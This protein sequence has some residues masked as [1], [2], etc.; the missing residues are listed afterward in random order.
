M[1]NP[2]DQFD[3]KP[4]QN[5]VQANPFNQFDAIKE[6][7]FIGGV[8]QGAGDVLAGAVR[9]AG[10]IGATLLTPVDAAFRAAGVENEWVGRTDRRQAMDEALKTVGA[11]T[12]STAFGAGKLG[13]EIAGTAAA[14]GVLGKVLKP[15]IGAVAPKL[16]SA[17]ETGGFSLGAPAAKT[18]LGKVGDMATRMAG[19]AAVG[20]T[21]AGMVDPEQAMAGAAIG[22][23]MPP[24]IKAAGLTGSALGWVGKKAIGGLTGVGDEAF[25]TAFKAG[26]EGNRAF[27]EN[28]RGRAD[29]TDVLDDAKAA[30]DNMRIA[31]NEAYASGMVDIRGDKAVLDF[32]G[33][34][35][36]LKTGANRVSFKGKP[37]D[38][39]AAGYLDEVEKAVG[40]WKSLY[41]REYHTPSGMDA[42]KKKI[43]ATLESI[44][45]EQKNARA[46]IGD[47][48]NSVKNEITKQAPKYAEVMKDYSKSTE[49]ISEIQRALIGG[50][51]ASADASLRRLQSL[52]RNNVQTNYGNRLN[53]AREL[54]K[55]GG[56]DILPAL[57]GQAVQEALPR[58]LAAKVGGSAMGIAGFF[59]PAVLAMAPMTSPRLM[60]EAA[61]G[62]GRAVGGTGNT[63]SSLLAKLPPNVLASLANNPEALMAL[64]TTA[65]AI[66]LT[67]P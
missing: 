51:R 20:G 27:V 53:L 30:L 62:V 18:F 14:G 50:N 24:A 8:A 16:L 22:G 9:G 61:Y 40:E 52:M 41:P 11:D 48:Y 64:R 17:I 67:A 6:P 29:M 13:T 2:F 4:E 12:E 26:K 33:I 38:Q 45:Y 57:A 56:K 54:E 32:A 39:K 47:I 15:A 65:P 25:S 19:G 63:L 21:A 35:K 36:A 66:A 59:N 5:T 10:S 37:V 34:D 31:K 3:T 43:G 28:M 44:P 7:S 58:S 23:A 42:L 1:A 55:Q 60:G 49:L 46:I